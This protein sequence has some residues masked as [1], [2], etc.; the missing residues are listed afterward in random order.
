MEHIKQIVGGGKPAFSPV[1]S[2]APSCSTSPNCRAFSALASSRSLC[3]CKCRLFRFLVTV[4]I[5]ISFPKHL[6]ICPSVSAVTFSDGGCPGTCG[7]FLL[8]CSYFH[9]HHTLLCSPSPPPP[10]AVNIIKSTTCQPWLWTC[11]RPLA[12]RP[13]CM[14]II[15]RCVLGLT[16][17][18]ARNQ[19]QELD[20]DSRRMSTSAVSAAETDTTTNSSVVSRGKRPLTPSDSPPPFSGGMKRQRGEGA[21]AGEEVNAGKVQLPSIWTSF[22]EDYRPP[23]PNDLRRASLPVLTQGRNSVRHAPYPAANMRHHHQQQQP[24]QSQLSS[25]EFPPHHGDDHHLSGIDERGSNGASYGS[26]SMPPYESSSYPTSSPYGS[27]FSRSGISPYSAESDNWNHHSHQQ[28]PLQQ[29]HHQQQQQLPPSRPSS[30]GEGGMRNVAYS[31]PAGPP[32]LPQHMFTGGSGRISGHASLDHR[33]ASG[34]PAYPPQQH[35]KQQQFASPPSQYAAPPS[36]N[37]ASSSPII[38]TA[39]AGAAGGSSPLPPPPP[40][41]ATRKRGKLPKETTDYLKAWLHRHQDHPYPSE[42][43]K[44]QLCHATGLSMSQVSNWM[45]NVS[46]YFSFF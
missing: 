36:A 16:R 7:L 46:L 41:Q 26:S 9:L 28:Q 32:P 6:S 3:C 42:E 40:I 45:I 35:Q 4:I 18:Y 44:K 13:S 1:R 21:G 31:N 17:R 23:P 19:E 2:P 43:E 39:N 30:T 8:L 34:P 24:S 14:S 25:Y 15:A 38:S 20:Y 37:S 12:R 10:A 22:Q 11:L 29:Q 33:R 5:I 27:E